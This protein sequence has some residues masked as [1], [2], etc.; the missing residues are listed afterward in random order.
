MTAGPGTRTAEWKRAVSRGTHD[1]SKGV[2][3]ENLVVV[4]DQTVVVVPL[5]GRRED[6]AYELFQ[7]DRLGSLRGACTTVRDSRND[8]RILQKSEWMRPVIRTLSA[9][10]SPVQSICALASSCRGRDRWC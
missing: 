10:L 7:A 5:A 4:R 3:L 6:I 9:R 1:F 8:A 2:F